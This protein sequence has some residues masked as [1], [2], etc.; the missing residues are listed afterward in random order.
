MTSKE[1]AKIK[2]SHITRIFRTH[3]LNFYATTWG[4]TDWASLDKAWS[5]SGP[6]SGGAKAINAALCHYAK[7]QS[8]VSSV[9]HAASLYY[10]TTPAK[11][12]ERKRELVKLCARAITKEIRLWK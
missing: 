11:L 7:T 9:R 6:C 4:F 5:F 10:E 12:S 3:M 8:V 1:K 2:T